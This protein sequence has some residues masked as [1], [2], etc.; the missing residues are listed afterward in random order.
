MLNYTR[1]YKYTL[2]KVSFKLDSKLVK[3]LKRILLKK[4]F[5][6]IGENINVRN[7]ITFHSGKNITIGDNSGIGD[8]CFLQDI[9]EIIIGNNVLM[10][11]E[12]L[13]Y[14]ANHRH[15]K[16]KLII[17]Q[18]ID[19]KKIVIEDDVWIGTR[20]IILPGVTIGKG[21]V[22]AA[23]AVVTKDI[24]PYAIAGGVPAKKI[25]ERS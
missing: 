19:T 17:E 11:P 10:G 3:S 7:N 14:T 15:K 5:Y 21:A 1:I 8:R 20:S 18:G 12:V 16:D 13:I 23:N 2:N 9:D 25:G 6:K 24:E 22:I 4:I